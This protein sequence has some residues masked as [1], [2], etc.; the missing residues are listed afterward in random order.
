MLLE[1]SQRILNFHQEIFIFQKYRFFFLFAPNRSKGK[2]KSLNMKF[3]TPSVTLIF[4]VRSVQN[5]NDLFHT[6]TQWKTMPIK[7]SFAFQTFNACAKNKPRNLI[8][9][10]DF[11]V[12]WVELQ[13]AKRGNI[14][15]SG[16]KWELK[17]I[18]FSIH[19]Q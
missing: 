9:P 4:C 14:C 5:R 17:V 11:Q 15:T 1:F 12:T 7:S 3:R 8:T 10:E 2:R 16:G 6:G 18:F 19:H 13:R